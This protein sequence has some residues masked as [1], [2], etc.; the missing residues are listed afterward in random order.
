MIGVFKHNHN[1]HGKLFLFC[2]DICILV[3][4]VVHKIWLKFQKTKQENGK[5][6]NENQRQ[7]NTITP[8]T[9]DEH[10]LK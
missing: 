7:Q 2:F 1:Q 5:R 10:D 9:N 6:W 3:E 4:S 8:L